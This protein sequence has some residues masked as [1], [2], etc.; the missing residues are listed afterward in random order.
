[1]PTS[2]KLHI[3]LALLL[4]LAG[5]KNA[6]TDTS[7]EA[8]AKATDIPE[9]P[10]IL[11]GDYTPDT[12]VLYKVI[13]GGDTCFVM[14]D[15]LNDKQMHGHYY[16]LVAGSDCVERQE[17]AQDIHWKKK[18]K[19]AIVYLYQQPEYTPF[20]DSSLRYP[21]YKTTVKRDIEYGQ[22]LGFWTSMPNTDDES[23]LKI[24]ADGLKKGILRSTQSLKMDIYQPLPVDDGTPSPKRPLLM[25]I[26]GGGFYVGDKGDSL[27]TGLCRHFASM[28]YVAVSINY[29]LGFLPTKKEIART[30]YMAL[31]DA[32]AA[33][34]FLIEHADEYAIDPDEIFVGGASAGGI[35]ALNLAFM[36]DAQRPKAVKGNLLRDL[37]AIDASGNSS[38]A[39]FH[40][41]AIANMWGAITNLDMLNNSK[42]DIISF[43]GDADQVVPY[44]NGF[45]FSD[46]SAK[47]GQRM[48]DRMYGSL[49]IDKKAR[50]TGLRSELHTFRGQGHSLHHNSDGS[51]S[52]NNFLSIRNKMTSFFYKEIAGAPPVIE[53]DSDNPRLFYISRED[54]SEVRW[55]VEGGFITSYDPHSMRI[56]VVWDSN[57]PRHRLYASGINA[58]KASA[59]RQA[60][61]FDIYR[62]IELQKQ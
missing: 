53:N 59:G 44:D 11:E 20:N 50:E 6:V 8:R 52:Q 46:I 27:M 19:E 28:G 48:F 18:R 25:L 24:L 15:S 47:L 60:I 49:Q 14:V 45:P 29:R 62:D 1:M 26:H 4:L 5:C 3:I 58:S 2:L 57:A 12:G 38:H 22:A 61:P 30:G 43:H 34:R 23:Y 54:V 31:Q 7:G 51:W 39:T 55:G 21:I 35:T 41:K 17:F 56:W 33:M 32:H 37:G 13:V 16:Q 40:I 42:T 9:L 36:R 10:F